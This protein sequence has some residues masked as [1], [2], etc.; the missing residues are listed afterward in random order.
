MDNRPFLV[1]GA[2]TAI[3]VALVALG[4]LVV[5]ASG[6]ACLYLFAESAS[7][8]PYVDDDA[9]IGALAYACVVALG[10]GVFVA[11]AVWRRRPLQ[12]AAEPEPSP[13]AARWQ[14]PTFPF[15]GVAW[16]DGSET[17][18]PGHFWPA[19]RPLVTPPPQQWSA[20]P[21]VPDP[22]IE[23]GPPAEVNLEEIRALE[24]EIARATEPQSHFV[25]E[26]VPTVIGLP[27]AIAA[28]P[29]DEVCNDEDWFT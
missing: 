8:N 4:S 10:Y 21:L 16:R 13:Y 1:R 20:P 25:E 9:F 5:P 29:D 24:E 11:P 7:G 12:Q 19:A 26:S 2:S 17:A 23:L 28:I 6:I 3:G 22:I 18:V 14:D 15:D 27:A